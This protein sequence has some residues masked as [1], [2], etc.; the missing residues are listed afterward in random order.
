MEEIDES[1]R[2]ELQPVADV[3]LQAC[4][5]RRE[6]EMYDKML[7]SLERRYPEIDEFAFLHD[8][9]HPLTCQT[10]RDEGSQEANCQRQNVD[11]AECL[12]ALKGFNHVEQC[13]AED[14]RYHHEERELRQR[15]FLVAEEQTGGDGRA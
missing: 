4:S 1:Q 5:E 3:F 15:L 9:D 10:A 2:R 6:N 8:V 13:L 14:G 11:A 12:L 7:A